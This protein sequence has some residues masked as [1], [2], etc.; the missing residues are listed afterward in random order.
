MT[1]DDLLD[2]VD[3]QLIPTLASLPGSIEHNPRA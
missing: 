3:N 1:G 2:F